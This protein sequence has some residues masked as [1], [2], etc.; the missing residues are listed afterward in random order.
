MKSRAVDWKTGR[1]PTGRDL[2]DAS[3]QLA[4]YRLAWSRLHGIPLEN[5]G[6]SFVYIAHGEERT[7]EAL[8]G[9][10]ELE[11]ILREALGRPAQP[12]RSKA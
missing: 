4:V 7:M 9:E 5:I 1:K 10:E 2:T 11:R 12:T 3:L 8:P 6:A